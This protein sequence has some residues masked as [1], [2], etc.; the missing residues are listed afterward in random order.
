MRRDPNELLTPGE[1]AEM[2]KVSER[3]VRDAVSHDIPKIYLSRGTRNLR[4]RLRDV[5]AYVNGQ[6]GKAS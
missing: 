3:W 2:L 6:V 1:V 5:V 4:F